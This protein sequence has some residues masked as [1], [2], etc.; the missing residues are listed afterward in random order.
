M[1]SN[2]CTFP[3]MSAPKEDLG[4]KADF[5]VGTGNEADGVGH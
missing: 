4:Q 5:N 2:V 1:S 3:H